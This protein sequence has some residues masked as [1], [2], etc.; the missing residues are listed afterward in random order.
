MGER[1]RGLGEREAARV[2]G[3]GG[4]ERKSGLNLVLM[5]QLVWFELVGLFF[6]FSLSFFSS[7]IIF[8]S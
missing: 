7:L 5:G 2:A 8:L 4:W 6:S 3:R 1:G